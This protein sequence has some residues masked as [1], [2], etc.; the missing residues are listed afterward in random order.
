MNDRPGLR[1][2]EVERAIALSAEGFMGDTGCDCMLPMSKDKG[3]SFSTDAMLQEM[4]QTKERGGLQGCDHS[5][6]SGCA[7]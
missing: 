2:L 1:P 4:A 5:C 6:R 7:T 3:A